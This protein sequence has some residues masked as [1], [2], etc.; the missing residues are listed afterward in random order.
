[1]LNMIVEP[2]HDD[3]YDIKFENVLYKCASEG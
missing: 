3:N 2:I 1:M